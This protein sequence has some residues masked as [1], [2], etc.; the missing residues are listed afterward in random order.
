MKN[1]KTIIIIVLVAG[2]AY[3][4]YFLSENNESGA[5]MSSEALSDF[6]IR[7]TA[8]I[9]K[10]I[11]TDTDGNPGVTLIRTANEWQSEKKECIQQ[12][13]VQTILETI[14]YIKVKSPVPKGAV[15]TTNKSIAAHHKKMEIYVNGELSKTWYVGNPTQDQYGTY[16][17]LKDPEKGKSPEPFIMHLP[18]MYGNLSTRFVTDPREFECTEVFRYDPLN[19]KTVDVTIPDSTHLNFRIEAL[20]DNLFKVYQNDR[21]LEN[22]DTTLVRSYLVQY[23]KIHFEGHNYDLTEEMIDSIQ[24]TQPFYTIDVTTKDG[25]EKGVRIFRRKYTYDKVGLDGELLEYDQDRVW[26][27]LEDGRLVV[28]QIYVFGRLMRDIRLFGGTLAE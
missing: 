15:E 28:G 19:I 5:V 9:D 6:A 1:L 20:D 3:L 10:L 16:M 7:D 23:K 21:N 8:Q 11:I 17:L 26:V 12:H 14:K 2:L 22:F 25:Q 27:E 18:N 13:L 4:A 24:A